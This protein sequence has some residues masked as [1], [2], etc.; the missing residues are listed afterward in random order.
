[1]HQHNL[2]PGTLL[3]M[4]F[5]F[6]NEISIGGFTAYFSVTCG[7]SG[8]SFLFPTRNKCPSQ[9]IIYLLYIILEHKENLSL[10]FDLMKVVN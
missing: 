9:D 5:A 7:T 1:M 3:H 6:I 8:M 4:D 10:L 2:P